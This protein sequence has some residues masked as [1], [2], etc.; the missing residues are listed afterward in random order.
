MDAQRGKM[1]WPSLVGV[2]A[3]REK[4]RALW[5]EAERAIAAFGER[6]W[7]MQAFAEQL[8]GRKK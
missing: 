7:F 6:A 4:S 3:S 1:T 2:Q 5:D 8:R